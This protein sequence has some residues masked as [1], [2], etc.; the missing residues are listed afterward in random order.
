MGKYS[1]GNIVTAK[2]NFICNAAHVI[3]NLRSIRTVIKD[4]RPTKIIEFNDAQ[5]VQ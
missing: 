2:V 5:I 1:E 3:D 4:G